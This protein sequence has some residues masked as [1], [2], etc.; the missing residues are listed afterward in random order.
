MIKNIHFVWYDGKDNNV[1]K[2]PNKYIG[3]VNTWK[4]NNPDFNIKIWFN[5]DI[6][7]LLSNYPEYELFF[8]QMKNVIC[9]CD[10]IRF[11]IVMIHGGVYIDL[12]FRCLKPISSLIENKKYLFF[13]EP[14]INLSNCKENGVAGLLFNG[15]FAAEKDDKFINGWLHT[16]MKN[17]RAPKSAW[18]VIKITGP[19]AFYEYYIKSVDK[20]L[21][22]DFNLIFT[23]S[24]FLKPI[25]DG[26]TSYASTMWSDGTSWTS[27]FT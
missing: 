24:K 21:I 16:M 23:R 13:P 7:S 19:G 2:I 27:D 25:N 3:Y 1:D 12:D 6:H 18:D 26:T 11:L 15:F 4:T 9:K 20:P 17:Y 14:T 22:S 10:F 8:G 5:K